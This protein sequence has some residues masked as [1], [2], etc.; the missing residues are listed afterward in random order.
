M[1]ST[2]GLLTV[3]K[4]AG[5]FGQRWHDGCGSGIRQQQHPGSWSCSCVPLLVGCDSQDCRYDIHHGLVVKLNFSV[6]F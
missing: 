5:P 6:E 3:S 1:G 2:L 4:P